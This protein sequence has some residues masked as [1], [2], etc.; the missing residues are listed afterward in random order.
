MITLEGLDGSWSQA[1]LA[2]STLFTVAV[3]I[4]ENVATLTE[5]FFTDSACD[6]AASPASIETQR[7]LVFDGT[8]TITA[9]GE[10]SNVEWMVESKLVD[11]V[12]DFNDLNNA[13]YDVMLIA[14]NTLYVGDRS[15]SNDGSAEALRPTALDQNNIF[16][17][18]E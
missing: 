2:D 5:S 6:T 10:A 9:T 7:S 1:C 16:T 15:G 17:L 3:M 4:A 13:V 14:N 11:G 18:I 8:T 12:A